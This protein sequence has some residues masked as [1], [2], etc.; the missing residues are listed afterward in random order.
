MDN[1]KIPVSSK[2]VVKSITQLCKS[3]INQ[4]VI[5]KFKKACINLSIV[6]NIIKLK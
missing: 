5:A 2:L 3:N 4:G 6:V 1:E